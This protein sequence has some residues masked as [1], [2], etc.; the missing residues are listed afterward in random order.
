MSGI[1]VV[2]RARGVSRVLDENNTWLRYLESWFSRWFG[3]YRQTFPV[4]HQS[5]MLRMLLS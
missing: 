4:C 5:R 1:S 3:R 2:V